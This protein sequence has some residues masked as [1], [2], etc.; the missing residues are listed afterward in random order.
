MGL[1]LCSNPNYHT[2]YLMIR[3]IRVSAHLCFGVPGEV[4][5]AGVTRDRQ[6][7][8]QGVEVHH[9]VA[10]IEELCVQTCREERQGQELAHS[11]SRHTTRDRTDKHGGTLWVPSFGRSWTDYICKH[12]KALEAIVKHSRTLE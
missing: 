7:K 8:G 3:C 11:E 10:H 6:Y 4:E 9:I 12:L 5:A 1:L 2:S